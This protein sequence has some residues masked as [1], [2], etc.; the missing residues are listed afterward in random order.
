MSVKDLPNKGQGSEYFVAL[1][2]PHL[3]QPRT[4][5]FA[6]APLMLL[7]AGTRR[8][9]CATPPPVSFRSEACW[10]LI[11]AGLLSYSLSFRKSIGNI[12]SSRVDGYGNS[13]PGS[14]ILHD[15]ELG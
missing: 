5:R 13:Q 6:P 9:R 4:P 8:F 14:A 7:A 15:K 12:N 2:A 11:L 3:H 10:L 1:G